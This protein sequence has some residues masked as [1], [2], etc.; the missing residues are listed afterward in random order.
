MPCSPRSA[1]R[2]PSGCERSTRAMRRTR[3]KRTAAAAEQDL[4]RDPGSGSRESWAPT[5]HRVSS[6]L[7]QTRAIRERAPARRT[8]AARRR[9]TRARIG[10]RTGSAVPIDRRGTGS[11]QARRGRQPGGRRRA[12][13]ARP[14]SARAAA[15]GR[16][17]ASAAGKRR[18]QPRDSTPEQEEFSHSAPGTEAF[19][20]DRSDWE[21]LRR[22][23]D[24]ALEKYEATV[25]GSPCSK[26]IEGSL[27]RGRQRSCPRRVRSADLAVLRV[28]RQKDK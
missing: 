27:Q 15:R 14:V 7:E 17:L 3:R 21:S 5:A 4:A 1:T 18:E 11:G 10:R 28:A 25:S 22:D 23:L 9:S 8:T 20:Q 2:S 19:K 26:T 24:T 13:A 12:A 16:A 6:E